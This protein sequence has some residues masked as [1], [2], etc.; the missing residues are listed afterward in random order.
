V[1]S[2]DSVENLER[3]GRVANLRRI[4]ASLEE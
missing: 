3:T 1:A 2:N 4:L